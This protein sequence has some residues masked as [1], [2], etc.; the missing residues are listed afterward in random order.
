MT[1]RVSNNETKEDNK[2]LKIDN[3]NTFKFELDNVKNEN[4]VK[5]VKS[6]TFTFGNKEDKD[7]EKNEEI[8]QNEENE[9]CICPE[10]LD[11]KNECS[12]LCGRCM[13]SLTMQSLGW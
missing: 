13:R 5:N 4:K 6:S 3:E 10:C 12:Q 1:K 8:K 9:D 7:N 2:K 11:E